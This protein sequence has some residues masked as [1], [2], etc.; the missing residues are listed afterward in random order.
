MKPLTALVVKERGC[1]NKVHGPGHARKL[2]TVSLSQCLA[3]PG[4]RGKQLETPH[5]WEGGRYTPISV[6]LPPSTSVWVA[7]T[8][9]PQTGWLQ[10]K[11]IY[12][13]HFCR[14]G[15]SRSCS[16]PIW[17]LVRALVLAAFLLFP[18]GQ[19]ESSSFFCSSCKGT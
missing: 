17:F 5:R 16:R 7:I 1:I 19:R 12:F 2:E 15:N 14:L 4:N 13:S 9:I 3:G 8:K 11:E 10:I 6:F 18:H